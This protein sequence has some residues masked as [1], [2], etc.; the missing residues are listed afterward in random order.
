M[1]PP[2]TQSSVASTACP[3]PSRLDAYYDHELVDSDR[4]AVESHLAVCPACREAMEQIA[5]ASS[6]VKSIELPAMSQMSRARLMRDLTDPAAAGAGRDR[7]I[8]PIRLL[9]TA[10]AAIFILATCLIVYQLRHSTPGTPGGGNVQPIISPT[11]GS[12]HV[13]PTGATNPAA[14]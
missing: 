12:A 10:A 13:M 2:I 9:T 8:I 3:P 7:W 1:T 14:P 4:R 11:P 6:L 5:S